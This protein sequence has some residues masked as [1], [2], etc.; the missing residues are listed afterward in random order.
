MASA[1]TKTRTKIRSFFGDAALTNGISFEAMTTSRTRKKIHRH[2][3]DNEWS[4]AKN[5]GAIP[6]PQQTHHESRYN[7]LAKDFENLSAPPKGDLAIVSRTSR[8]RRQGRISEA[9]CT[10]KRRRVSAD[11]P[12]GLAIRF[13]SRNAASVISARLTDTICRCSSAP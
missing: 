2:P 7:K 12:A 13:C 9:G 5:V 3:N 6:V 11:G 4:I 10:R 8:G 1:A